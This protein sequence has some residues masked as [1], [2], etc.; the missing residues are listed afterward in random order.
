MAHATDIVAYT[1][2]ADI[3][4]PDCIIT[5]VNHSPI[6]GLLENA[7][8]ALDVFAKVR[9]IDRYD[10]HSYDSDEFPKV[11]FASH[12]VGAVVLPLMLF[13]QIQLMVCSVLAQR[14][15]AR[16]VQDTHPATAKKMSATASR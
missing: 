3:Y 7:E 14:W 9:G 5:Q 16:G 4:C 2:K 1:Y 10:E 8:A 12:A 15:G 6:A 11:I 13:H